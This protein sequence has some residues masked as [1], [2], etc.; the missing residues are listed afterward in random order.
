M[1]IAN[2]AMEREAIDKNFL[3]RVI[4]E[5]NAAMGFIP[6][7]NATGETAQRM[8]AALGIVPE[9]NILSCGIVTARDEE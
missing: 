3:L 1:S 5:Q 7:P 6:D 2:S 9:A 4:G 8:T